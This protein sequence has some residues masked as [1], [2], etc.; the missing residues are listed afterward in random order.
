MGR[1]TSK[2]LETS[3]SAGEFL[4]KKASLALQKTFGEFL[5]SARTV[6][7]NWPKMT[8]NQHLNITDQKFQEI[9]SAK[10]VIGVI[11]LN[12]DG[13]PIKTSLNQQNTNT[14]SELAYNLIKQTRD[15][16]Q[17]ADATNDTKFMR[18]TTK[19]NEIMI[20]PDVQYTLVVI[21]HIQDDHN[22]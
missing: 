21:Q 22:K 1:I 9:A 12:L 4:E 10:N 5:E 3:T 13:A 2:I 8:E 16:I 19:R 7:R 17:V 20:C 14:Y 6:K 15:L 11:V 18:L